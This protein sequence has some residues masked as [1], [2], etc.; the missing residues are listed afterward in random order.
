MKKVEVWGCVV[1]ISDT[2]VGEVSEIAKVRNVDHSLSLVMEIGDL[3]AWNK[4][5]RLL[6]RQLS[7]EGAGS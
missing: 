2:P 6:R 3:L 4:L 7:A 5:L 1:A